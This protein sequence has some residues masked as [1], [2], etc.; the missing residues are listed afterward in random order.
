MTVST[1][2]LAELHAASGV[3]YATMPPTPQFQWPVLTEELDVDVWVKH[4]NHAPTGAFK[5]RGGLVYMSALSRDRSVL[6]VVAA[7]R[8]N[9]G[10]SVA[11]AAREH[12]IPVT[13]VVPRGNSVEKNVA[14]RAFGAEVIEEGEDFQ[15]SSEIAAA[16]AE[17][18]G[19]HRIPSFHP[20]L[21]QGVATYAH[22]LLSVVPLLDTVYV[23]IGMGSGACGAIAA[24]DALGLRT[25]IVGVVSASA[26]ARGRGGDAAHVQR[27]AQCRR[28]GWSGR[29]GGTDAGTRDDAWEACRSRAERRE[30]GCE[31]VRAGVGQRGLTAVV[32]MVR[33]VPLRTRPSAT[34]VTENRK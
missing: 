19:L 28:G 24:R 26:P 1:P 13:I 15:E 21:V 33:R 7:T 9:H 10:Q 11:F 6:G 34:G 5:V 31:S 29:V 2:S 20:L 27:D 25:E 3:V 32:C 12:R 14:M 8:G 16:L 22:E 17:R 18:N 30:R 23:P 4:E